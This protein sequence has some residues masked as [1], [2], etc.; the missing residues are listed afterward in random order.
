[1]TI[2]LPLKFRGFVLAATLFAGYGFTFHAVAQ[3]R[4]YLIDLNNRTATNLGT[5]GGNHTWALG[6]NNAGQVVGWS[7]SPSGGRDAFM[8]GPDGLG[9]RGFPAFNGAFSIAYDINDTGQVVG[10]TDF[11]FFPGMPYAFVTG[12]NGEGVK[13]FLIANHGRANAINSAGQVVGTF[14]GSNEYQHA[15][16]AIDTRVTDIETRVTDLGGLNPNFPY[17]QGFGI[18]NTGQAVGQSAT[19][20][21]EWHA[22]LTGRD[23]IGMRDL[24]ALAG[25][26]SIAY[27]INN[28]GEV[29]G[30]SYTSDKF[31]HAFITGPAGQ[32]MRDLGTLSGDD[33]SYANGI[34]DAGLVVGRSYSE[35]AT[36][37]QPCVVEQYNASHAFIT[38]PHGAGMTDLNSL[39][40]LPT[41]VRLIEATDINN[42]GQVIAVA[43]PEPESYVMLLAGLVMIALMGRRTSMQA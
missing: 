18:N 2:T 35:S 8:T 20:S 11:R 41:G 24:G 26:T 15:F 6:V 42:A 37:R 34:N 17:S 16:I 25:G 31:Q 40:D 38:G 28:A 4:S 9:M 14:E 13:P 5:L 36:C 39:V 43:I 12:P 23:G 29:A 33:F 10:I 19:T 3:E 1:M 27:D 30:Y 21:G 7:S 22:F 32:G